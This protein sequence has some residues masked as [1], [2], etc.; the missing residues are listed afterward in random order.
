MPPEVQ[1][2]PNSPFE[3]TDYRLPSFNQETTPKDY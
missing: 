2:S 3:T 1:I